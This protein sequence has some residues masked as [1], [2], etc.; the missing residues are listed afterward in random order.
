M[1]ATIRIL[2]QAA[3]ATLLLSVTFATTVF[4]SSG[5]PMSRDVEFRE[6]LARHDGATEP[7]S[8][9]PVSKFFVRRTGA[10]RKD[11]APR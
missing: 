7:P 2:I 8:P 9:G 5:D 3:A 11:K 10:S 6:S 4:A 1:T